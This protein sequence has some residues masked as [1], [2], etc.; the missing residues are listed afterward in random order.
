MAKYQTTGITIDCPCCGATSVPVGWGKG[1]LGEM[2]AYR[3][4]KGQ[5]FKRNASGEKCPGL[6]DVFT[7]MLAEAKL[8]RT[9]WTSRYATMAEMA[10]GLVP[11]E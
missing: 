7:F 4:T 8:A 6:R 1:E 9:G 3:H 5:S 11:S 2:K 10:N